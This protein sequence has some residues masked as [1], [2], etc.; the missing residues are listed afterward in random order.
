MV[1]RKTKHVFKLRVS[2][3]VNMLQLNVYFF[4]LLIKYLPT[5]LP[6]YLS[7]GK[8]SDYG[9]ELILTSPNLS[10]FKEYHVCRLY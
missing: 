7:L 10:S 4:L 6:V 9:P 1:E 8:E 5:Y 2:N 3:C